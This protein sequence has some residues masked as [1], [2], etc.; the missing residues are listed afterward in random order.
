MLSSRNNAYPSMSN[1]IE[2]LYEELDRLRVSVYMYVC[3]HDKF[4]LIFLGGG[5]GGGGDIITTYN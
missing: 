4:L 2:R 1:E 5:G 3:M